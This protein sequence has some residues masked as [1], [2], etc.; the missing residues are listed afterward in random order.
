MTVRPIVAVFVRL[1]EVPVR[2]AVEVPVAAEAVADNVN[3]LPVKT[4]VTPAGKLDAD[5]VTAPLNPFKSE[6]VTVPLAVPPST[7]LI[8]E[9]EGVMV[10][11]GAPVT[12]P[13]TV[14]LRGTAAES[15]PDVPVTVTFA[16]PVVA[17]PLAARVS[18]LDPVVVDWLKEAVTPAGNPDTLIATLPVNPFTGTTAIAVDALPP[19]DAVIAVGLAERRND[20]ITGAPV[21]TA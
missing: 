17:A 20:L 13:V 10:K 18:V 9:G 4:A 7:R 15:V 21:A 11:P 6:T 16:V 8:V 12:V 5:S 2:V 1:P 19:C 14:T 3:A